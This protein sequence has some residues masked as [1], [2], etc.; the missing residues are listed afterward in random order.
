MKLSDAIKTIPQPLLVLLYAAVI[1]ILMIFDVATGPDLSFAVFYL[2]PILLAAWFSQKPVAYAVTAAGAAAWAYADVVTHAGYSHPVVPFWNIAVEFL[3]F[4]VAAELLSRLKDTLIVEKSLARKDE[5]TGAANRRAF[6][7]AA[8]IEIDR[9]HRYKHPFTLAY[10]DLDNFKSINDALGHEA[11]DRVLRLISAEILRTIRST[12]ILARVGGDEFVLLLA[13]T[14]REQAAPVVEK[15]R[16]VLVERMRHGGWPVTFSIGAI[17]YLRSPGDVDALVKKADDLMY[18][19][20]R[21]GKDRVSYAVWN[22][23]ASAR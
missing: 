3:V 11:G 18:V 13:E 12:D 8:Q 2:V 15:I 9:M 19:S 5:L 14:G 6:Y 23:S 1:F 22:E 10:I 4:L 17:T 21:G 7:E 20:K 16:A